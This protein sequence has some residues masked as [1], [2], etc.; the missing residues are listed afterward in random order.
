MLFQR[1]ETPDGRRRVKRV[2]PG[3]REPGGE[4]N[5]GPKTEGG[6]GNTVHDPTSSA[7]Y[8]MKEGLSQPARGTSEREKHRERQKDKE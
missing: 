5:P 8:L 6:K 1:E 7:S 3:Y 4:N 2:Q